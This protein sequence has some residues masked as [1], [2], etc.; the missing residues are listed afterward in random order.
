MKD[1][2]NEKN[3]KVFVNLQENIVTIQ[4]VLRKELFFKI[5]NDS[6]IERFIIDIDTCGS[7]YIERKDGKYYFKNILRNG[8]ERKV[9]EKE[10]TEGEARRMIRE[11]IKERIMNKLREYL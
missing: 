10:L 2:I 7:S 3:V 4:I 5:F 8:H 11:V 1:R 6:S 9:D